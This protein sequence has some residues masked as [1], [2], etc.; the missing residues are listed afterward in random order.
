MGRITKFKRCS[1]DLENASG[2]PYLIELGVTSD[3]THKVKNK[4]D[5]FPIGFGRVIKHGKK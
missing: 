5:N 1:I 3:V 4:N 2:E